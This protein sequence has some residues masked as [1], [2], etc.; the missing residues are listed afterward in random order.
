MSGHGYIYVA[1]WDRFQHYH[2]RRPVW[3]KAYLDLLHNDSFLDLSASDRG[4]LLSVWLMC[5]SA[6]DGRVSANPTLLAR[7]LNVRRVSLE[8]LI[9]A[10]FIH[11]KA[12]KALA[13]V[14]QRAR[15]D[16][17]KQEEEIE[18]KEEE[19]EQEPVFQN[20]EE[21]PD[22]DPDRVRATITLHPNGKPPDDPIGKLVAVLNADAKT[23]ELIKRT[24]ATRGLCEAD[25]HRVREQVLERR[26][27]NPTGYAIQMLRKIEVPA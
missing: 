15:A 21:D 24:I 11:V 14:Y 9:E 17:D 22:P 2:D 16:K 19:Q 27:R 5:A 6:G 26:P 4:V 18:T 23:E 7:Q 20:Q 1:D 10:G 12:S 25:V 13:P 8:P 3:I